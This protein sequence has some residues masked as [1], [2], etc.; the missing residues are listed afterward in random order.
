MRVLAIDQLA[1]DRTEKPSVAKA[2]TL[3]L[4]TQDTQ[5]VTLAAALGSLSLALRPAGSMVVAR[6]KQIT[7]GTLDAAANVAATEADNTSR[8]GLVGVTRAVVRSQYVVPVAS[9]NE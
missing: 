9:Y 7:A 1:D 6:A 4:S 8:S 3:E 2:V 5:R